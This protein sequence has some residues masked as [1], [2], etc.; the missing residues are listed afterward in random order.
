MFEVTDTVFRQIVADL[1]APDFFFTEFVNVEA[2][3]S[4]GREHALSRLQYSPQEKP[5]IAQ[6]WGSNPENYYQYS[7]LA[8]TV[9]LCR[10]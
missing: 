7:A 4:G 3:N 5:I 2:L 9:W 6:I 8:S 1:A 10:H